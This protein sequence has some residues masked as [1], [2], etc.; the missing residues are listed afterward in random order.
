MTVVC[1]TPWKMSWESRRHAMK[2]IAGA[3]SPLKSGRWHT[4]SMSRKDV[5]RV[6]RG[7]RGHA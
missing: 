7:K 6:K 4:T 1:P 3:T 5:K 2:Q